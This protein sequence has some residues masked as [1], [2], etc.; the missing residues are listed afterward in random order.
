M[1]PALTPLEQRIAAALAAA[2]VREI[3]A[4]RDTQGPDVF[5]RQVET[6]EPHR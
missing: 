6:A 2:L 5:R 3:R 1:S 4:G